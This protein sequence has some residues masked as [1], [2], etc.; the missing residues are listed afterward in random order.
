MNTE[1][2]PT[3]ATAAVAQTTQVDRVRRS[4]A[5]QPL[6]EPAVVVDT[7]S[8]QPP[9]ELLTEIEGAARLL[10]ALESRGITVSFG[11]GQAVLTAADGSTRRLSLAEAV[12]LAAGELQLEGR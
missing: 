8:A 1:I 5:A 6:S 3:E 9:P 12:R 2:P 4:A 11:A 7:V 10:D